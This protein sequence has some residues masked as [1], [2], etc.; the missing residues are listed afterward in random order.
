MNTDKFKASFEPAGAQRCSSVEY[1]AGEE[2][3]PVRIFGENETGVPVIMTHG[4]QSHSGWFVQSAQFIAGTGAPVYATDRRGSGLSRAKRGDCRNFREMAADVQ[5]VAEY[6]MNRHDAG[7]VHVL[8]H[9]FGA[10][11]AAVFACRYPGMVRSLI[12]STPGLY[13]FTTVGF[14]RKIR[15]ILSMMTGGKTY[16]PVPLDTEMFSELERYRAFIREDRL[17]LKEATARFFFQV[18]R[19]RR[20]IA[21]NAGRLAMPVFM[22]LAGNDRICDNGKNRAFFKRLP[23][24]YKRLITYRG[25]RHI[26]EFSKERE[27]FFADLQGWFEEE[28]SRN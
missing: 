2:V 27:A 11:P 9:C 5:A 10:I 18:P 12:L 8:G 14:V 7:Q 25:A 19:A 26:L 23:S 3:I 28:G 1:I 20:F 13:T 15:I 6:A 21:R 17:S 16:I 24:I 4:L 22:A